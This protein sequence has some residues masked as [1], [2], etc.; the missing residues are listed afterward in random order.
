MDYR[1]AGN[2]VLETEV[3]T[4]SPAQLRRMTVEFALR[5]LNLA[6][7][8]AADIG[9]VTKSEATLNLRDA[10]TELLAGIRPSEE[11]LPKQVADMYVF[12][13]QWL[14]AAETDGDRDKLVDIR[15]VLEIE[16]DTWNQ[17][18]ISTIAASAS[19]SRFADAFAD[20]SDDS[21]CFDA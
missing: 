21:I 3:L 2:D 6:I 12:L 13:T 18:V 19:S 16:L 4:A 8:Q 20:D 10:L 7:D 14:T 5:N 15:S 9:R 1:Q 11:D 17:V